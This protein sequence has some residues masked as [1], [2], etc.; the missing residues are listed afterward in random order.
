MRQLTLFESGLAGAMPAIRAAMR[1]VAG[2][3]EGE[4]RKK[5]VD[6]INQI[7][8]QDG[9]ALTGGNAKS[10]SK[11]TL[12]KWLSP[13]DTGHAPSVNAILAFCKATGSAEP[14][15]EL[16]RP[17]GLGI[18]TP[19]ARRYHDIGKADVE[20]KAARK[21]KKMLEESL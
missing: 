9:I 5:L 21:R 10:I 14:L 20:L 4:G 12:D 3:P 18:M 15:L 1:R 8:R 6:S 13:S 19:E 11:D 2:D 17:F 7:A 16:L